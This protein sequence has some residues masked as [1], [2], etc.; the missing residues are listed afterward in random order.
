[1]APEQ[2][3]DELHRKCCLLPLSRRQWK[4]IPRSSVQ[5]PAT[6]DEP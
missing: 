3:R 4:F 6:A 5:Y 2:H 1:M